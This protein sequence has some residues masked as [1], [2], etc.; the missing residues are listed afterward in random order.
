MMLFLLA[1]AQTEKDL[2]WMPMNAVVLLTIH[3]DKKKLFQTPS[4]GINVIDLDANWS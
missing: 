3:E 4:L 1:G 2:N